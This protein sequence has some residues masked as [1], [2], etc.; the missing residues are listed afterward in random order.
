MGPS[1]GGPVNL[2]G[3]LLQNARLRFASL[4]TANLE[5]A[6]MS[7]ADLMHARLDRANLTAADLSNACLD[8]A[9]LDSANLTRLNLRG[10]SLRFTGLSTADLEAADL[11]GANLMHARL[12]Q[13]NLCAA[14][15]SHARLDYAD[16]AGADLTR[17][18]LCGSNLQNAKNLVPSQLAESIGCDSTIL[19][20]HLQGSVSWS[21]ATSQVT[22]FATFDRRIPRP[23]T[24]PAADGHRWRLYI[25]SRP[26]W[27]TAVILVGGTLLPTGFWGPMSLAPLSTSGGPHQ[28]LSEPKPSV[29]IGRWALKRNAL[30]ATM[31]TAAAE[32]K[33]SAPTEITPLHAVDDRTEIA[34]LHP[35]LDEVL[36]IAP[37]EAIAE[38]LEPIPP[39]DAVAPSEHAPTIR[40]G[41]GEPN[42][43]GI[44]RASSLA[45]LTSP[46]F[47]WRQ[48]TIPSASIENV[49][50]N[51][52]IT[53]AKKVP[54]EALA[55]S[56]LG[57]ATSLFNHTLRPRVVACLPSSAIK[58]EA[59]TVLPPSVK[60]SLTSVRE[61][62]RPH[63]A[64]AE[65]T[66]DHIDGEPMTLSVSLNHQQIDVYRGT[67]LI[68][69][70]KVSSGMAGHATKPGVFS[71]LDKQKFHR[72]NIYSG[73][74]MPWM[75]RLTRSGTALHGGVVP[76]YPASHG[77]I[78]L[79]FSFAPRLYQMTA[80]GQNVIVAN[81]RLTPKLIEH[82][83]LFQP[84]PP[85]VAL[86]M[87]HGAQIPLRRSIDSSDVGADDVALSVILAKESSA[88]VDVLSTSELLASDSP[89][90]ALTATELPP[91]RDN[92]GGVIAAGPLRILV[93]RR[94]PRDQAIGV[95]N[96]FSELGYLSPQ[97]FDGTI[98]KT[99]VAAI[100][101][102]QRANGLPEN[103]T[104]NDDLVKA[105]YKFAGK[106]EPPEGHLFV[107]QGFSRVFDVAIAIRQPNQPLGTHVYTT[108]KFAPGDTKTH[109]MA[110]SLEGVDSAS[111]LGRIEIPE[112]ARQ[113]IS[114]R[115]T[116]GSSLIIADTSVD[117]AILP[118]GDDFLVWSDNPSAESQP[119]KPEQ[120]NFRPAKPKEAVFKPAKP[121]EAVRSRAR[122][123]P[124][125]D[126][127][128]YLRAPRISGPR[129][130]FRR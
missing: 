46:V 38:P 44:F 8:Y 66:A 100:K 106:S 59:L 32:F 64:K 26:I 81:D 93:T 95:Q 7:G 53:A 108:L 57:P 14:N 115:L 72:S 33:P 118:E 79:P 98:G 40:M 5:D 1:N 97:N 128:N 121:K 89:E 65:T 17:V 122:A 91:G 54:A 67:T 58:R 116:P 76:G 105:V 104:F 24:R 114:E 102:F 84:L 62:A 77:C 9:D 74:P 124:A 35:A 112:D 4:T 18:N 61:Q 129:F 78:R 119:L 99:T 31:E 90:G 125:Y 111:V 92:T 55:V 63:W 23:R 49:I 96:I 11:S 51:P 86:A 27:I 85:P 56:L 83:N 10:A 88:T 39:T 117:S 19:P 2:R 20:P 68:T 109:W 45:S 21:A 6:D 52:P 113:Q 73:A 71:I 3:A 42:S 30:N 16:F 87:A 34:E 37:R 25:F 28:F 123:A 41:S 110:M 50:A 60:V 107:R 36:Q 101:A 22:E 120:A 13:A 15:L 82:P 12:N 69:S 47:A 103:G 43:S 48:A 29:E 80:V 75:Q 94:T 126:E 127:T 130:F 70:S